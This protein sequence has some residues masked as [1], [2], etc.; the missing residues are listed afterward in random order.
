MK[1]TKRQLRQII[2]ES[3]FKSMPTYSG[4]IGAAGDDRYD[5]LARAFHQQSGTTVGGRD[6]GT[7]PSDKEE[8]INAIE[9]CREWSKNYVER[10]DTTPPPASYSRWPAEY[11]AEFPNGNIT[12]RH[13]YF[14]CDWCRKEVMGYGSNLL[15]KIRNDKRYGK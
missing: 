2:R 9:H 15:D 11:L 4:G 7:V 3:I 5:D 13:L 10:K 12:K 8:V 1:I 14:I 6:L